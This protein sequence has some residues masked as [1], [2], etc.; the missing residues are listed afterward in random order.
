MVRLSILCA[1]I[2]MGIATTLARPVPSPEAELEARGLKS[3]FKKGMKKFKKFEPIVKDVAKIGLDVALPIPRSLAD[4]ETIVARQIED[5]QFWARDEV[6]LDA[7]GKLR[8]F[9]DLFNLGKDIYKV[10][11]H[12]S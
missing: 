5:D 1:F 8:L 11:K 12:K 4:D 10:A 3:V 7:R 2:M 6:D 9:R